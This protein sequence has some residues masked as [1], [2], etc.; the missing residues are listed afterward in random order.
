VTRIGELGTDIVLLRS[1]F[2]LLVTAN[3]P[4]SPILVTVMMEVLRSSE[5]SV[6]ITASQ[7]NIPEGG[8]LHSHSH[9][10]LK[11]IYVQTLL[12]NNCLHGNFNLYSPDVSFSRTNRP[13]YC[14]SE[15]FLLYI[16]P[17]NYRFPYPLFFLRAPNDR[18]ELRIRSILKRFEPVLYKA[19]T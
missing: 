12:G 5:T 8:L 1:V 6:L 19:V 18:E 3:V 2:R 13:I 7:R 4:S 16:G 17:H 10:S 14:T 9:E 15:K 11:L